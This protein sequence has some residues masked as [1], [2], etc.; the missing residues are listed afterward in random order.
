MTRRIV[1]LAG[2]ALLLG[3]APAFPT[4][5]APPTFEELVD[6]ANTIF[7]G[8]TVSRRSQRLEN[9]DGPLIVTLVTFN[10]VETLKGAPGLQ[11]TLEFMGGTVDDMT[12]VVSGM[13]QFNVGDKDVVFVGNATNAVSPLFGFAH[14]R[15]RISKDDRTG[16]EGVRTYDGRNFEG[17]AALGSPDRRFPRADTLSLSTFRND[18]VR[19]VR[20]GASRVAR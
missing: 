12:L 19:R 8:E 4:T 7:V 11:M 20:D 17:T 6:R 1:L 5:V 2:L 14:G 18:I 15:F 10:V 9:R 3:N 13:P 16:R